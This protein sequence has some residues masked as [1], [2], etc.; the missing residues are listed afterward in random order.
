LLA[1]SSIIYSSYFV[2]ANRHSIIEDS[3]P[4]SH[5][6]RQIFFFFSF[7]FRLINNWSG[8]STK[9]ERARVREKVNEHQLVCTT[10]EKK[11]FQ[12]IISVSFYRQDYFF[13]TWVDTYRVS[14]EDRFNVTLFS[15]SLSLS[16]P[17][18]RRSGE[19][20]HIHGL[21]EAQWTKCVWG[22]VRSNTRKRRRIKL[23][24]CASLIKRESLRERID[25]ATMM[26]YCIKKMKEWKFCS[27]QWCFLISIVHFFFSRDIQTP[28]SDWKRNSLC[29]CVCV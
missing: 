2:S 19:S 8:K 20:A 24:H 11:H 14:Y 9:S 25:V 5:I 16:L 18:L 3:P 1:T 28:K 10:V 22:W 17:N 23:T 21:I 27:H 29:V 13:S 7:S 12:G 26:K 4:E 6:Y 15:L